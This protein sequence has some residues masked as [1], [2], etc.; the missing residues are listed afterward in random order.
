MFN[1][2]EWSYDTNIYEVNIR[3]Y[4]PQGTFKAFAAHMPRLRNM[5]VEVLWFMP[6][7]PISMKGRKGTLGSYYACSDYKAINPEFGTLQ[8]FQD[9]V[10]KAHELGFKVIIDWVANHTGCDHV[11][12]KEHP[13]YYLRNENGDFYD[14]HGWD[15]VID[16]NYYNGGLRA[17]M[18]DAMRFWVETCDID[19]F[20]CDMA[21]LVAVDFWREARMSLDSVKPL[22]WL[23]ECDDPHYHEVFDAS[24]TWT[25]MHK[26][27][28]FCQGKISMED[29]RNVLREQGDRFPS[30]AFRCYFT[31]NHD[32]NSWNG[33]EFE[34]YGSKAI[35][36]AVFSATWNGIPLMYSG[37][38]LPNLKRLKFFDKDEIDW[39]EPFQFESLYK[40]LF[41]LRKSNRALRAAD[42][43]VKTV[44]LNIKGGENVLAFMRKKQGNEV[45]VLLNLN[46]HEVSFVIE[47]ERINGKYENVFSEDSEQ[48]EAS[49]AYAIEPAGFRLFV[50]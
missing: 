3:Q 18:I 4:T 14:T 27:Q 26:S 8:D 13:D 19:G 24:Y 10:R 43:E 31:T 44:F 6:V 22:F 33:T 34:K 2:V 45:I 37:Q 15:D 23:A 1:K 12:T 16:L 21:H 40:K 47:D 11:W 28:E 5:S 20:R 25:W 17:A 7:T 32:E 41:Q 49:F 39:K 9:I 36:L 46:D 48:L 30:D 42:L 38:E 35:P 29:L 50:K